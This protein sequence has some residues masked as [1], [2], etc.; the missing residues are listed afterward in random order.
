MIE[1][2]R[3][4]FVKIIADAGSRRIIGASGAGPEVIETSHVVQSAIS[5][6]MTLEDYAAIPHYHPTL[7]EA[8]AS[9]AQSA[10]D[11]HPNE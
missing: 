8:W 4:G 10:I 7:A 2:A 6:G 9:A 3:H 1:G 11:A 5:T